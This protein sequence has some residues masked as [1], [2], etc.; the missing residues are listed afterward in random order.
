MTNSRAG[1]DTPVVVT[2]KALRGIESRFKTRFRAYFRPGERLRLT[3]E[4]EQDFV[5]A[6]LSMSSPDESF[7]LDLE[8]AMIVQD[9]DHRFVDATTSRGRLL[10]AIEFLAGR[11]EE[12]FRSQRQLRFHI[13]WRLYPFQE[14]TVRFRGRL[15]HPELE[16]RATDLLADDDQERSP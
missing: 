2:Q 13:D 10:G 1:G 11:L 16:E 9:Q 7:R 3:V 14:S 8:A 5:Y 6:Q 12:Y 15:R 4:D